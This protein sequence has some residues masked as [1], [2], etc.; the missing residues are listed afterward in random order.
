MERQDL[1]DVEKVQLVA[2]NSEYD[3]PQSFGIYRTDTNEWLGTVGNRYH[4]T[5]NK[6]LFDLI[7]EAADVAG[8]TDPDI[9]FKSMHGG[10]R[11]SFQ[12]ELPEWSLRGDKVRR[13]ATALNT[14]NGSSSI[15]YGST[16]VRVICTNTWYTAHRDIDKIR[17][18]ASSKE[19]I[20]ILA[21]ALLESI[22]ID[23]EMYET[24]RELQDTPYTDMDHS[25]F[26]KEIVGYDMEDLK[27]SDTRKINR[28]NAIHDAIDV[29]IESAGKNQW[30]LFNGITR[31]TNH[32]LAPA[33]KDSDNYLI[34]GS[35]HKMHQK[36]YKVLVN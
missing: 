33:S 16:S 3:H 23:R 30:G 28:F 15:G 36:A 6:H 29:E 22:S 20:R 13:Y 2:E 21:D 1:F 7:K 35:G 5:Q 24:F 11:V 26:I 8:M 18:T 32:V 12:L 14:H 31:Y 34:F 25:K 17:H 19:R 27:P 10:A 4:P 9:I